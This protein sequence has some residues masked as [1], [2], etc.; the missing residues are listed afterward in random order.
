MTIG[1]RAKF[2]ARSKAKLWCMSG[3]VLALGV[4]WPISCSLAFATGSTF[5]L[6]GTYGNPTGP[7]TAPFNGPNF[8]LTFTL[9]DEPLN[10][11]Q[12]G[13][14]PYYAWSGNIQYT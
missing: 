12:G 1:L 4:L 2:V 3:Q 9:P 8:T 11:G 14:Y 13:L 6:T 10:G 5:Q 7:A